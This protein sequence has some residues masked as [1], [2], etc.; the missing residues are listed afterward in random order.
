VTTAGRKNRSRGGRRGLRSRNSQEWASSD[1]VPKGEK[2]HTGIR[3]NDVWAARRRK[4]VAEQRLYGGLP[5]RIKLPL[6]PKEHFL[7][8]QGKREIIFALAKKGG[9]KE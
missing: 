8:N 1:I 4:G 5:R 7:H 3:R 6:F 9:K 2:K